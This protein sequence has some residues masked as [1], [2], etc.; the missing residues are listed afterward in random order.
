M[1]N[2]DM[3]DVVAIEMKSRVFTKEQSCAGHAFSIFEIIFTDK[4][5]ETMRVQGF[6]NGENPIPPMFYEKEE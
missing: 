5:G 4:R 6:S 2:V 1:V 3:H